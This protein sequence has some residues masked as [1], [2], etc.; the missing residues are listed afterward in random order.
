MQFLTTR[1]EQGIFTLIEST[2]SLRRMVCA[3]YI[4]TMESFLM[5]ELGRSTFP[6]K[7]FL[8][9]P[10]NI[11]EFKT[12]IWSA[13]IREGLFEK[14][15]IER[16]EKYE[17]IRIDDFEDQNNK[18]DFK[19]KPKGKPDSYF[20]LIQIKTSLRNQERIRREMKVQ[21]EK[22]GKVAAY[23]IVDFRARE[24]LNNPWF[25]YRGQTYSFNSIDDL[26]DRICGDRM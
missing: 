13:G 9:N 20:V 25:I 18:I 19:I 11:E 17:L 14:S 2:R 24:P 22:Y 4:P 15:V 5:N 21:V 10:K 26:L 7:E 23:V 3:D 16:S 1:R 6:I 8:S 12:R